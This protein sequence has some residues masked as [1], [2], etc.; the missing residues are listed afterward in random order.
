MGYSP[1]RVNPG[2]KSKRVGDI[3][4]IT[5]G[6][7]AEAAEF[8]DQLYQ[9]IIEAGT[10][11]AE[12]IKIAEAAKIIENIQRD[13][14]I[15]LMNELSI[16]FNM[17]NISTQE[18]LKAAQ[19]KWN[20]VPFYPG[21]VGGHCIGV[22][23]YYLAHKSKEYGYTPEMILAGRRINESMPSHTAD[24]IVKLMLKKQITLSK[25][26]VLMLGATF[27]ENCPDLRNSK[28][29]VLA[30]N[31]IDFGCEVDVI[32]PMVDD[33][34]I[35]E[36][37]VFSSV[38]K[39]RHGAYDAVVLSV[40]HRRFLSDGIEKIK[41]YQKKRSVFYDVRCAFGREASDGSL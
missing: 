22:D 4:K 36:L 1:E 37:N 2:D 12:S 6:S 41:M 21:L 25:S 9:T 18:V 5:S 16:I 39:Q 26:R 33:E 3:V 13:V 11:K 32:D 27:K 35:G 30:Q 15:A 19:T 7:S 28:S 10:H 40:P 23:P 38:N 8:V 29:I 24:L 34:T 14:N 20:F 31:L 17:M